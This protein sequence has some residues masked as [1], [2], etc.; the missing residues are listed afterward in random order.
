MPSFSPAQ[1]PASGFEFVGFGVA[2]VVVV[3]VGLWVVGL[4]VVGG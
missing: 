1:K 4:W 2:R 3:V